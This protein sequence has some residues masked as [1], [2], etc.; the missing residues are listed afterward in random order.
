MIGVI[1]ARSENRCT[2]NQGRVPWRLPDEYAYF[3]NVVHGTP[4]IM[5][6]LTHEDHDGIIDGSLNIV[7]TN[8]R[9]IKGVMVQPALQQ[10]IRYALATA[11]KCYVI[12]GATLIRAS[13]PLAQ[14]VHETIVHTNIQGDT[15]LPAYDFSTWHRR[16]VMHH[17]VDHQHAHSFTVSHF[18]R[19]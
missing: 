4:V 14:E 13:L 1:Y 16:T 8:R 15:Y 3:K 6:R 18:S 7:V 19:P 12:G 2:G 5:G 11:D 17:A 9:S 10:A